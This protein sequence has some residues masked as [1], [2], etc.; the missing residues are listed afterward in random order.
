MREGEC[1]KEGSGETC[2]YIE[3]Y[4][5]IVTNDIITVTNDIIT[6]TNDII[7]VTM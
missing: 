1:N 5:T 2:M 3:E 7:T 4:V 6:V